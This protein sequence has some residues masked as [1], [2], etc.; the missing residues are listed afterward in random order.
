MRGSTVQVTDD[1][2]WLPLWMTTLL[3]VPG[4]GMVDGVG[5]AVST[6]HMTEAG[7]HLPQMRL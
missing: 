2:G 5:T 4:I 7:E 1:R 3:C 6:D